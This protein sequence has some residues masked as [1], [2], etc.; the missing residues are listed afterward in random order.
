MASLTKRQAPR[1]RLYPLMEQQSSPPAVPPKDAE[2]FPSMD[3]GPSS[4]APASGSKRKRE[5]ASEDCEGPEG[6]KPDAGR[7]TPKRLCSPARPSEADLSDENTPTRSQNLRRKKG[8]RNLSNL[9]LRHAADKQNHKSIAA[10]KSRESKFQ[11]GS[12]T[13]KPSQQ[14]PTEFTQR[15]PTEGANGEHTLEELIA[16]YH[17]GMSEHEEP[18]ARTLEREMAGGPQRVAALD[19]SAATQS[20]GGGLFRFGAKLASRFPGVGL[21]NKLW[22]EPKE[23]NTGQD[24][25]ET[26]R[27]AKLKSEAEAKYAEMKGQGHFRSL[28]VTNPFGSVRS[29]NAI[30]TP[31]DSFVELSGTQPRRLSAI[32]PGNLGPSVDAGHVRYSTDTAATNQT[33]GTTKSR[34]ILKRPSL[35]GIKS[36]LKRARSDFNLVAANS[37]RD[38]SS[39]ISPLKAA[40][41]DSALKVSPSKHDL[42]K[43]SKLSKRVSDLEGKLQQARRELDEALVEASPMPKFG[44]RFERYTPNATTRKAKFIPGKLQS[45]PSERVLM[46]QQLN[47]VDSEEEELNPTTAS[48]VESAAGVDDGEVNMDNNTLLLAHDS[49]QHPTHDGNSL[50]NDTEHNTDEDVHP[51]AEQE[52]N[53]DISVGRSRESSEEIEEKS[54][55]PKKRKSMAKDDDKIYMPDAGTDDEVEVPQGGPKKKRKSQGG[56]SNPAK[57]RSSRAAVQSVPSAETTGDRHSTPSNL[58][59]SHAVDAI[60]AAASLDT[61]HEHGM[62]EEA[63]SGDTSEDRHR[64]L[65]SV[66]HELEP[67][68]E[69]EEE[70]TITTTTVSVGLSDEP[71]KPTATATPASRVRLPPRSRSVSPSKRCQVHP[72][73]EAQLMAQAAGAAKG[74]RARLANRSVSPERHDGFTT[75]G[76]EESVSVRP[77]ARGVPDLPTGA[78]METNAGFKWPD[79]VF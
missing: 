24:Y 35:M 42:K 13:D 65:Q 7:H 72:G 54:S 15:A 57:K 17:G 59:S 45:L 52:S 43:Q 31:H 63:G 74:H 70:I 49:Q 73:V 67:L 48:G 5:P 56:K 66:A 19:T 79:D 26:L 29:R 62:T 30:H 71:S 50:H 2:Y 4:R 33:S 77:G 12:L 32:A 23:E 60:C 37:N 28:S 22:T 34:L 78:T 9:N 20:E 51:G 18:V 8:S 41:H 61:A 3:A 16:D 27:K 64:S 40:G 44:S 39:S 21:W 38:S 10:V 11:E 75:V 6:R 55:K 53:S 36:D 46:A 58:E 68:V 69:V 14:P 76:D 1:Q 25:E 47:S